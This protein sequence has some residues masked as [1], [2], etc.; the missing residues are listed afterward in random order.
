MIKSGLIFDDLK[1]KKGL[2]GC[3]GLEAPLGEEVYTIKI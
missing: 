3:L 1:F 2:R